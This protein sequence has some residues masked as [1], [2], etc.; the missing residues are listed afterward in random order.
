MLPRDVG[1]LR[2]TLDLIRSEEWCWINLQGDLGKNRVALGT[3]V[4]GW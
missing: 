2:M 4:R 3:C 1:N